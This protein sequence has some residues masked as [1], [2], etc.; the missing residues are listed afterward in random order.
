M[1]AV[2]RTPTATGERL[3]AAAERLFLA[4][5]YDGA[6]SRMITAAARVNLAAVNYHFGGKNG[7][8]Q[9][10]LARRLDALHEERLALLDA[11]ERMA[12]GAALSCERIL[13]ALFVPA[14]RL[15]RDPKRGGADFL[16]LLGRAYVDPSP[17]L[18]AFLSERYAPSIARFKDAFAAA[19]PDIASRELAWRLHFML[20]ALAYTLAGADAWRLIAALSQDDAARPTNDQLLLRRLA[21]FLI[22]GLKAPLPDLSGEDPIVSVADARPVRVTA[23]KRPVPAVTTSRGSRRV[24]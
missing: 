18:R 5:G 16:R 13:A 15:A 12:G 19:L 3:L 1:P 24:A 10:M 2:S 9:A 20:G 8:F 14:L 22:A 7:L 4:H 11:Y 17:E 6:S 23:N 21:P